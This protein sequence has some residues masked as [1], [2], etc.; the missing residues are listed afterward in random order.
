MS[1]LVCE[2]HDLN[3]TVS[4]VT[5]VEPV[6]RTN[7]VKDSADYGLRAVCLCSPAAFF[8]VSFVDGV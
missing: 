8:L 7:G 2:V 6:P 4:N 5:Q 1:V 3:M